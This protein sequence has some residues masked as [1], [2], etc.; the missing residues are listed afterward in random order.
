[1]QDLDRRLEH[2]DEFEQAL[3]GPVQSAAKGIGV[4]IGL[5]EIFQLPDVDLADQGRDILIVLI[6]W[7]G[8]G[9]ADLAQPRRHQFDHAE[10]GDIAGQFIEALGCP[11]RDE[12]VEAPPRYAIF[13]LQQIAHAIGMKQAKRRF[14]NRADLVADLQR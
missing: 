11:G 1:M 12:P 13:V 9:N 10:L 5:T 7:L 6:A 14:E 3:R 8:L 4:R 2:L